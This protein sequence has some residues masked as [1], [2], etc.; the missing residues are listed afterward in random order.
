[1]TA[2]EMRIWVRL[3]RWS[4]QRG[5]QK[6]VEGSLAFV[7]VRVVPEGPESSERDGVLV[8]E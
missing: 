1:M 8:V 2:A 7:V 5:V 4:S 6:V 3:A